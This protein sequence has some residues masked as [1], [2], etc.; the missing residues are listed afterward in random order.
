MATRGRLVDLRG[1]SGFV[2]EVDGERAGYALYEIVAD[3]IEISAL[4]TTI[5]RI[6]AGAALLA[7]CAKTARDER[8]SRLWLITTNDNTPA[9][10]FYQGHGFV[11]VALRPNA[12]SDARRT[13]KP[14]IPVTGVDDIPIRDELELE[15]PS[16]DWNGFIGRYEWPPI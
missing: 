11:L 6:G 1:L 12:A 16:D 5:Q 13:L 8:L 15:L 3:S 9:L 14:D 10:R 7:A 2:A 4:E